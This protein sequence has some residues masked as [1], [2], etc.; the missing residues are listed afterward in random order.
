M[1][2]RERKNR[3]RKNDTEIKKERWGREEKG[4]D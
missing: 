3:I 2:K 4:K 1:G